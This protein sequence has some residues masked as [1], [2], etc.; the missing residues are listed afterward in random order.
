MSVDEQRI[1]EIIKE[2]QQKNAQSGSPIIPYHNQDGV[3]SP[4]INSSNVIGFT[5]IPS[6]NQK[7]F[8]TFLSQ[9]EFGFGKQ[10]VPASSGHAAQFIDN[11]ETNIYP[12]PVVVGNGVGV[13]SEFNGGYAP[14]GT[15]ALFTTSDVSNTFL[16]VRYDGFW[17]SF[18]STSNSSGGLNGMQVFTST[19]TFTVPAG[20]TNFWVRG[21]GGGGG[22]SG[23][24]SSGSV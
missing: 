24:A 14:D 20:I 2:E 13:Q 1:R 6:S 17:Y 19:G 7:F 3:N 23:T 5:P 16:Q 12:I 18:A 4:K 10:L 8:N 11:P 15:V 9:Y 21:V 22:G